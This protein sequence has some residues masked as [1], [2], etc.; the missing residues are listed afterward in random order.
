MINP[1]SL[2]SKAI[3]QAMSYSLIVSTITSP[4]MAQEPSQTEA[5][6]TAKTF[7]T[8]TSGLLNNIDTRLDKLSNTADVNVQLLRQEMQGVQFQIKQIMVLMAKAQ[9]S[10]IEQMAKETLQQMNGLKAKLA[11]N[12]P[13]KDLLNRVNQLESGFKSITQNTLP[14]EVQKLEKQLKQVSQEF[15]EELRQQKEKITKAT[16]EE[17]SNE[18][19]REQLSQTLLAMETGSHNTQRS[20]ASELPP[21]LSPETQRKIQEYEIAQ[22]GRALFMQQVHSMILMAM[23]TGNPYVIAA[24]ATITLVLGIFSLF[25]KQEGGNGNNGDGSGNGKQSS[26]GTEQ[27]NNNVGAGNAAKSEQNVPSSSGS[28]NGMDSNQTETGQDNKTH[29]KNSGS[30]SPQSVFGTTTDGG[31]IIQADDIDEYELS[32]T[33]K[34]NEDNFFII[35]WD[36]INRSGE[37][38]VPNN[39]KDVGSWSCDFENERITVTYGSECRAIQLA[40]DGDSY[41]SISGYL[42]GVCQ[43]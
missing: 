5:A 11:E 9:K 7:A 25:N 32:F 4:V 26:G 28:K 40:E 37:N 33:D 17:C 10:A 15:V 35:E 31:C 14:E 29:R 2:L 30:R 42:G 38:P 43:Q 36:K 23:A 3:A 24:A 20:V 8:S 21:C 34:N 27:T 19:D 16:E 1:H 12:S 13:V 6:L 39:P 18:A 41:D 22:Q